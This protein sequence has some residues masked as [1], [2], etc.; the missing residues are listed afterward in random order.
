MMCG[1]SIT[2]DWW[3]RIEFAATHSLYVMGAGRGR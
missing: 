2:E 3:N 1:F